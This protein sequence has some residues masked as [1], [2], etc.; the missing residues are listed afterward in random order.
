MRWHH[1][2]I[3]S[4]KRDWQAITQILARQ[5]QFWSKRR[6]RRIKFNLI[7]SG[8][9]QPTCSRP[10][11]STARFQPQ[12][13]VEQVKPLT[14]KACLYVFWKPEKNKCKL[15]GWYIIRDSK[16]K[17]KLKM[18]S[19]SWDCRKSIRNLP[20]C[21]NCKKPIRKCVKSKWPTKR[22]KAY[23]KKILKVKRW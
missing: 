18:T 8:L 2:Q 11:A 20:M 15:W 14:R 21:Q 4:P 23:Y 5:T 22:Q 7:N 17:Y 12:Q 9:C 16:I 10:W 1:L 19:Y 6:I 3:T 13:I